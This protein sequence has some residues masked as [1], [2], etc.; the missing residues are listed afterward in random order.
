MDLIAILS[1]VILLVT[2][3]T[4]VVALAA[5]AAVKVRDKR[6]PKP[7]RGAQAVGS[8]G[9]QPEFLQRYMPPAA[10]QT[11]LAAPERKDHASVGH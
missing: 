11:D 4:V 1:T 8:S 5:Y 2:V 9:F 6:K 10:A 3:G 7:G